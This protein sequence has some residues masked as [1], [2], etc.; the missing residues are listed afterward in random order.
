MSHDELYNDYGK[1][2]SNHE[3]MGKIMMTILKT[4]QIIGKLMINPI[5]LILNTP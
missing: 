5:P 1:M 4:P 3:T 2:I